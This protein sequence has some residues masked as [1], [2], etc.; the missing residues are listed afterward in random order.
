MSNRQRILVVIGGLLT[1]ALVVGA[2]VLFR[3]GPAGDQQAG[4]TEWTCSMHPQVRQSQ[5]GKCPLCGMPL[6]PVKEADQELARLEERAGLVVEPITYR[7]LFKEIR[8]VGRLDYN[9]RQTKF[10]TARVNGLVRKVHADFTGIQVKENDHLVDIY[11]P[12]LFLGQSELIRALE[13]LDA[14]RKTGGDMEGFAATI[15]EASRTKLRLLGLLEEQ[16]KEIDKT[17]KIATHLTIYAPM[18][19]TVIEKNVRPGQSVK[20]GDIL[21]K[22][23][24][25]D[26]IWLYLDLYESDLGWVRFGQKVDVTV[27]AYPGE[28]F[29]GKVVFIDPFLDDK[30]RTVR[31]RINLPNKERRLKPAMYASVLIHVRLLADGSPEPTGLEGKYVCPMHPEVISDKEGRCTICGMPLEKVPERKPL[32]APNTKDMKHEH[33]AKDAGH[34]HEAK[35]DAKAETHKHEGDKHEGHK[36]D[37]PKMGDRPAGKVL[38]IPA[39]AVLDTGRRQIAY[40]KTEKGGYELVEV[41]LGPRAEAEVQPGKRVSYFPVLKGLEEKDLVVVQGAFLLDSQ[42]QIEGMP[43]LLFPEG[44]STK[45]PA[46]HKH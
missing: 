31:A 28:K 20:E 24:D 25:L 16:L 13:A 42:R 23:A 14:A 19:G 18:G 45:M 36:H 9:E 10:I 21:Y 27:E 12:D 38:A 43:S 7:E 46:G 3:P 22:I 15:V 35:K 8:T 6:V 37:A 26:P 44:R 17:R 1:I 11:S 41:T 40:R 34:E 29:T 39:S 30:T 32:V 4:A 33:D 5:P 2:A